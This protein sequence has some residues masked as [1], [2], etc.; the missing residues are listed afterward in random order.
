[1]GPFLGDCPNINTILGQGG[2]LLGGGDN[3][4][5]GRMSPTKQALS[6]AILIGSL[7]C[8]SA[9]M[10]GPGAGHGNSLAPGQA[11][12]SPGQVFQSDKLADPTTA[13]PP[14]QKFNQDRALTPD[15]LPPG[16]TFGTP[17]QPTR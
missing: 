8:A 2:G 6:A 12:T 14:G 17:G 3:K 7:V 11:G 13:V 1:M 5:E 4:K 9:A 10:A 16:K 15:T